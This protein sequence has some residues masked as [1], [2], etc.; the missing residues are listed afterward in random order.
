MIYGMYQSAAGMMVNEYRQSVISNNIANADTVGFKRE[1]ASFAERMPA[2]EAGQRVGPSSETLG[3]LSGGL[4]LG[5]TRTDH[6]PGAFE[7][8]GEPLDAAIEG[9]GFFVV[10]A[11]GQ[12]L[13]TR[14]GRFV[15]DERG[16]LRSA[17]DGAEV[18]GVGGV[19]IRL[20]PRAHSTQITEDGDI[21]QDGVRVARL[22]L[23]DF[24]DYRALQKVGA[25]RFDPSQA[26]PTSVAARVIGGHVERSG[27]QPVQEMV[28]M[29]EAARAYQINAQMIALQD[30]SIG[31]L[32]NQ[33]A[34]A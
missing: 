12:D 23:A 8:T 20:N 14:D 30:Q 9:T 26:Q 33:V 16:R 2:A 5:E 17:A 18:L 6:A 24:A 19:P 28:Q 13:V 7:R 21:R 25:G 15:M 4:W 29:I 32:I 27:T 34:A 10:R 11:A 1:I 3:S 31:R 22:A